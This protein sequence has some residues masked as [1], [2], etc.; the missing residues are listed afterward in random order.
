MWA[1]SEYQLNVSSHF[2]ISIV[3]KEVIGKIKSTL[4]IEMGD[5]ET[6]KLS[7]LRSEEQLDLLDEI[8]K[9]RRSGI[10]DHVSFPQIAV[11][12]D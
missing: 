9:L 8:D 4:E 2:S 10:S 11:C 12:R 3:H 6:T 7:A 5:F 1:P